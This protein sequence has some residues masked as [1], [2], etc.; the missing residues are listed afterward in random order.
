MIR[1]WAYSIAF[2][3]IVVGAISVFL[4]TQ[5]NAQD[6]II[7]ELKS[8]LAEQNVPVK[9]IRIVNRIPF[10]IE[11]TIQSASDGQLVASDDPLFGAIV[12]SEVASARRRGVKIDLM[13]I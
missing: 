3:L 9:E 7:G 12:Q 1:K 4:V 6:D 10:Q 5:V 13:R 11:F 2:V 8:K